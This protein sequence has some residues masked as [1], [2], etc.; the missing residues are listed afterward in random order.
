MKLPR[1]LSTTFLGLLLTGMSTS[2]WAAESVGERIALKAIRGFDNTVLG[3]MTD[4]PKTM[5]YQSKE[6][7]LP[8]GVTVGF[9]QGM[10][11]GLARTVVGVYELA[12]FPIPVPADYEP[13]LHPHFA[14]EPGETQLAR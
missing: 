13:V 1:W 14:H 2:A 3:L 11:V 8:Y 12:T 7:G 5:Y 4:W 9:V 6:H 10:A